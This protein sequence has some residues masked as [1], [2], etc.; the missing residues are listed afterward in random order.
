MMFA[1]RIKANSHKLRRRYSLF[2]GIIAVFY[3]LALLFHQV[4]EMVDGD[5]HTVTVS[6]HAFDS[7]SDDE[8]ISFSKE[9]VTGDHCFAPA[10]VAPVSYNTD[11]FRQHHLSTAV[12]LPDRVFM[13]FPAPPPKFA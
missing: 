4:G 2:L 12:L 13:S 7:S 10:I 1:T 6:N 11:C 5:F 3:I 8:G 9:C